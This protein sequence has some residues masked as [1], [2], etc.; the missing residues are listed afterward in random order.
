MRAIVV[1]LIGVALGLVG[2]VGG[3]AW[4]GYN[5]VQIVR[6]A[7]DGSRT[8]SAVQCLVEENSGDPGFAD[9]VT[10]RTESG[11]RLEATHYG[12]SFFDVERP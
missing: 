11:E 2:V 6:D 4:G 10:M 12:P 1:D 8:V 7:A 9:K 5:L 3:W